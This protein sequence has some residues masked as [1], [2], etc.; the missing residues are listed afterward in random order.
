MQVGAGITT[1]PIAVEGIGD[2]GQYPGPNATMGGTYAAPP[3]T[4][5]SVEADVSS[6][7]LDAY[8]CWYLGVGGGAEAGIYSYYGRTFRLFGIGW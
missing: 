6:S 8:R 7:D 4:P 1:G 5:L 2:M 3:I